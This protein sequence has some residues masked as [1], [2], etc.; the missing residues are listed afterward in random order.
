MDVQ[1]LVHSTKFRLELSFCD[2]L[3]E[4]YERGTISSTAMVPASEHM[5]RM[6]GEGPS[7][8]MF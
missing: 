3:Q 8:L 5:A 1:E 4:M 7:Q 2:W 6:T